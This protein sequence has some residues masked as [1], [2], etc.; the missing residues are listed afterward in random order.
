M[1]TIRKQYKGF[2]INIKKTD[3]GNYE[4]SVKDTTI[5]DLADT[6]D[7]AVCFAMDDIEDYLQAK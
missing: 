6:S 4:Y 1:A 2:K 7:N 5:K 3:S